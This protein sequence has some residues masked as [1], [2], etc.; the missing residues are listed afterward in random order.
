MLFS[1]RHAARR[2]NPPAGVQQRARSARSPHGQGAAG[3]RSPDDDFPGGAF[4]LWNTE[5]TL[6][7]AVEAVERADARSLPV[8]IVQHV[9]DSFV[10]TALEPTPP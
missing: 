5:I 1:T 8:V 10:K 2:A 6:Q 9:A 3:H 7:H 4:P